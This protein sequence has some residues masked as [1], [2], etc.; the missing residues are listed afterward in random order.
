MP[1]W[2]CR[3]SVV[4]LYLGKPYLLYSKSD[5]AVRKRTIN[6]TRFGYLLRS[7]SQRCFLYGISFMLSDSVS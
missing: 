5:S 7:G 6:L 1:S 4:S 3:H 2:T